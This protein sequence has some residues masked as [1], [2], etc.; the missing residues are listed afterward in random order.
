MGFVRK[1]NVYDKEISIRA[2]RVNSKICL[3]QLG[4]LC[5]SFFVPKLKTFGKYDLVTNSLTSNVLHNEFVIKSIQ[6]RNKE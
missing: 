5:T 2:I 4:Y 1:Q 6:L 3:C